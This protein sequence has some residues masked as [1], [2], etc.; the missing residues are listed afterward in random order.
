MFS[1]RKEKEGEE[2]ERGKKKRKTIDRL[3]REHTLHDETETTIGGNEP[4]AGS[5]VGGDSL[6]YSEE[7]SNVCGTWVCGSIVHCAVV[8]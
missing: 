2:R 5:S 7:S 6:T 1:N 8:A 4:A 3:S